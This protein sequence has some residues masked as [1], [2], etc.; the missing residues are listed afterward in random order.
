M[1]GLV[2][3][4]NEYDT[5]L[6]FKRY[7]NPTIRMKFLKYW[8]EFYGVRFR[9]FYYTIQPDIENNGKKSG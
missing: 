2:T 7:P 5:M 8:A 3:L 9:K 6:T 1:K 4:Y